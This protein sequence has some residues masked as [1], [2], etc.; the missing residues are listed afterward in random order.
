MTLLE[1]DLS[2]FAVRQQK[3]VS[4]LVL[5]LRHLLLTWF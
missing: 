3:A 4:V 1:E 2:S 5:L